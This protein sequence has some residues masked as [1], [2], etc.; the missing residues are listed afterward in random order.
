MKNE[1]NLN[2]WQNIWN[3]IE[4]FSKIRLDKFDFYFCVFSTVIAKV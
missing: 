1:N 4:K 3:K 2:P